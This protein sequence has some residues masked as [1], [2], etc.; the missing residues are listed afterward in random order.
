MFRKAAEQVMMEN[1]P[2]VRLYFEKSELNTARHVSSA[3]IGYIKNT[4]ICRKD[5]FYFVTM[6]KLPVKISNLHHAL[7]TFVSS[8]IV[9]YL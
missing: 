1:R 2:L 5:F 3:M 7:V 6:I 9:L 8:C 4:T